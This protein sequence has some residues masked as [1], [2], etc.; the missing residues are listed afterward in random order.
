MKVGYARVS[1]GGQCIEAQLEALTE[2][3]CAKVFAFHQTVNSLNSRAYLITPPRAVS[4]APGR[5]GR[6]VGL[7]V[8]HYEVGLFITILHSTRFVVES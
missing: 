5:V 6:C 3:G 7:L 8:R 1:S 4:S 2:Y